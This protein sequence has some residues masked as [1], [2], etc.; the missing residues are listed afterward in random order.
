MAATPALIKELRELTG[1]GMSDCKKALEETGGDIKKAVEFLREKGLAAAE[2]KSGRIAAEGVVG[3]RVL[4]DRAAMV[5]VNSETDFVAKNADFMAYV[6]DV[7]NQVLESKS[8]DI[9]ALLQEKWAKGSGETVQDAL[10]GKIATIG[11]NL[12]IR[13]FVRFEKTTPGVIS[14]YVHGGGKIGVLLDVEGPSDSAPLK[15][16][17]YNL[18]MQIAALFPKY[19]NVSDVDQDF[20]ESERKILE[21][22]AKNDP[23]NEKKPPQVIEK[24]VEGRLNK[25]LK[26][27]CLMEQAY[28]KDPQITVKAYIANTAK[29][30]GADIKLLRFA[31]FE[32]GEG[33]EKKQED[34]AEEVAKA[35]QG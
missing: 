2:K 15:E 22:V 8:N 7:V 20:I 4:A 18:C 9:E 32:K 30:I 34:F 17:A 28:V 1:S 31:C 29:E 33:I 21:A 23:A 13:R 10:K 14:S 27:I 26:E 16:M 35:M 12:N 5:E 25:L 19:L 6:A 24:M 3:L 11:E